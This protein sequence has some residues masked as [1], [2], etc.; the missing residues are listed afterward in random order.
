MS[1]NERGPVSVRD[2]LATT[3]TGPFLVSPHG[4]TTSDSSALVR[5]HSAAQDSDAEGEEY[6]GGSHTR[7]DEVHDGVVIAS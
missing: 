2:E 6:G 3:D 7:T 1:E 4:L 5:S